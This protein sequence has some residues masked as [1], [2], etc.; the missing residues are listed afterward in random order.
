MIKQ[1]SGQQGTVKFGPVPAADLKSWRL[2]ARDDAAGTWD[3]TATAVNVNAFYITQTPLELSLRVGS[4]QWRWR[5][6]VLEIVGGTAR[7]VVA[8]RPEVR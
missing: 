1:A 3:V 6:V 2:T 5:D 7:G 8:G 4:R